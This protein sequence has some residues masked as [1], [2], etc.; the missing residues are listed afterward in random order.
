MPKLAALCGEHVAGGHAADHG[1]VLAAQ[2]LEFLRCH[3]PATLDQFV[4]RRELDSRPE[5]S[6]ASRRNPAVWLRRRAS[7]SWASHGWSTSCSPGRPGCRPGRSG[8]LTW[9]NSSAR[10]VRR[11]FMTSAMRIFVTSTNWS[12]SGSAQR[13]DLDGDLTAIFGRMFQISPTIRFLQTAG[14]P[15][16]GP[17]RTSVRSGVLLRAPPAGR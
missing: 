13:V 14:R 6:T 10:R 11:S 16:A 12:K 3:P 1:H 5:R 4:A 17:A 8:S 2:D 9:R 7:G 15:A